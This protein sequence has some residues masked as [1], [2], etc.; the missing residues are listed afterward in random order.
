M[1]AFIKNYL[2]DRVFKLWLGSTLSELFEQ[3]MGLPQGGIL[4]GTLF[5]VKI[6][7]LAE[8]IQALLD[9]SL[10][11]DDMSVSSVGKSM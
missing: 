2:S 9:K 7:K 6:N 10:F 5:I 4:S 3:E 8:T 1:P 11:V